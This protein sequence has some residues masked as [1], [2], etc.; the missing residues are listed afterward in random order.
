[1]PRLLTAALVAGLVSVSVAACSSG[2][3]SSTGSTNTSKTPTSPGSTDATG[4]LKKVKKG[5][6]VQNQ[7]ATLASGAKI[8]LSSPQPGHAIVAQVEAPNAKTWSKPVTVF[9][10]ASR[11]CHSIKVSAG[12]G[13]AAAT[14]AC[15]L[16]SQETDGTETSFVLATTNGTTWKRADL[17]GAESKPLVSPTGKFAAW[18]GPT[19]F[20][21]WSPTPGTF[22]TIHA[23]QSTTTPTDAVLFDTGQL[24]LVKAAPSGKNDCVVTFASATIAAPTLH[25]VNSTLPQAD[26][27]KCALVSLS[28]KPNSPDLLANLTTQARVDVNGKKV[29]KTT[30][31]A[32]QFA[33]NSAGHWFI[34]Q[35]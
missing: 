26:K 11:F 17:K 9:Q 12:G 24:L 27:P 21:I 4:K 15:G 19:S 7:Y 29:T 31:F 23:T 3:P 10:D 34:S 8:S 5:K 13:V 35:P 33:K 20:L 16:T 1:M 2:S 14:I 18:Q 25:T 30:T 28:F 32:W 22:H 6:G